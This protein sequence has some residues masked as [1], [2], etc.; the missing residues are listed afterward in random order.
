MVLYHVQSAGQY[1]VQSGVHLISVCCK[2][3]QVSAGLYDGQYDGHTDGHKDDQTA[4]FSADCPADCPWYCTWYST[5]DRLPAVH[6]LK[7]NRYTWY[8]TMYSPSKR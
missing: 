5:T 1:M 6:L 7:I 4:K 3:L 2:K 8:C